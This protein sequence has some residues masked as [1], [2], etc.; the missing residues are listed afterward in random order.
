MEK[1]NVKFC[2]EYDKEIEA[3]DLSSKQ[4]A[5]V[6][7]FNITFAVLAT[8]LNVLVFVAVRQNN[9]LRQPSKLLLLSLVI[10]DLGTGVITQPHYAAYL[11]TRAA[12]TIKTFCKLRR[13]YEF[14]TKTF[15]VASLFTMAAISL[16]RYIA[17][18]SHTEY[19]E[20]VTTK[21]VCAFFASSWLYS[22]VSGSALYW[23]MSVVYWTQILAI[24]FCL[25]TITAAYAKIYRGLRRHNGLQ[26]QGHATAAANALHM[27]KY[28]RTA[29][30]MMWI[31]GLFLL[32][33]LP[34]FFH[35]VLIHNG[36][37]DV[38]SQSTKT[39]LL[40]NSFINPLV[41]C[42][43]LPEI[44]VEVIKIARKVLCQNP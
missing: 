37:S 11:L 26:V 24:S 9:S 44:R 10:T 1:P 21:R 6:A 42:F 13:F 32:C 33:Y 8:V 43:R 18:F 29:S 31:Y 36:P 35:L 3:K 39:L 27:A 23:D 5:F 7:A 28:R 15:S 12:N 41:Y 34:H 20:I 17:F 25:F 22:V 38:V 16:D 4:L 30:G 40:L 19:R 14:A 2:Y